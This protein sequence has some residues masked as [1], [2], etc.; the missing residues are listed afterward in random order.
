[1]QH[2]ILLDFETK[3]N[4]DTDYDEYNQTEKSYIESVLNYVLSWLPVVLES[5]TQSC[6]IVFK[7]N[8]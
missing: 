5:N 1:M 4:F 7:N 3:L 2:F 8:K 6:P